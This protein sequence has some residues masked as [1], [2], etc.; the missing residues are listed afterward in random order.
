[1]I[2]IIPYRKRDLFRVVFG[3]DY[4]FPCV[5]CVDKDD[6]YTIVEFD[7]IVIKLEYFLGGLIEFDEHSLLS[8]S[9]EERIDTFCHMG[10]LLE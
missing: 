9:L 8:K 3:L 5:R 2:Y 6:S 1:M 4:I 10:K 7:D